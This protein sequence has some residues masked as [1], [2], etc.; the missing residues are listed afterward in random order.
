MLHVCYEKDHSSRECTLNFR[1]KIRVPNNFES[2][3]NNKKI[4]YHTIYMIISRRNGGKGTNK[5]KVEK[6]SNEFARVADGRHR[7]T[8]NGSR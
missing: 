8:F 2:L 3:N 7:S 5:D 1:Q 6:V 4:L